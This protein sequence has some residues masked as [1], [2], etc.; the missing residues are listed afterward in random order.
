MEGLFNIV[1]S[2]GENEEYIYA[3]YLKDS[4]SNKNEESFLKNFFIYNKLEKRTYLSDKLIFDNL[5]L[6]TIRNITLIGSTEKMLFGIMDGTFTEKERDLIS[7]SDHPDK[8]KILTRDFED[9][10]VLLIF[11]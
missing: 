6:L 5:G 4:G 1:I 10:P 9:N 8:D 7:Q 11:Q 3:N 2:L